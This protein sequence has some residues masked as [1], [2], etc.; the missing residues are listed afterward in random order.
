MR[1]LLLYEIAVLKERE[2]TKYNLSQ[3]LTIKM[4]IVHSQEVAL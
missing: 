2:K 1:Q 4:D 3:N